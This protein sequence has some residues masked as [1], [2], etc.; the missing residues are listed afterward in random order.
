ME[1][2]SHWY[3]IVCQFIDECDSI[4]ERHNMP[5]DTI[6]YMQ[7]KE[8]FGQLRVYYC[9]PKLCDDISGIEYSTLMTLSRLIDLI[10]KKYEKR[11][12]DAESNFKRTEQ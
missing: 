4:L 2:P 7:I 1:T 5:I 10:I 3:H 6:E 8:K 12:R 9:I 11:I